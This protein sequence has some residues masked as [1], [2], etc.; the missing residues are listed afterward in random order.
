M[1][2]SSLKDTKKITV[3]AVG[4][5][6]NTYIHLYEIVSRE[7]LFRVATNLM[8]ILVKIGER[9]AML[10]L[11]GKAPTIAKGIETKSLLGQKRYQSL[12]SK[13][14]RFNSTRNRYGDI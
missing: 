13:Q 3:I 7:L 6:F 4:A 10:G 12:C 5:M 14:S 8:E 2:G 1:E 11:W 9:I